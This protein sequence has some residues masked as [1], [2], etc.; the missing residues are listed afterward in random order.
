MVDFNFKDYIEI[1]GAVF[2]SLGGSTVI[3]LGLSKWF[4]DVFAQKL[5][6]GF[7]NRHEKDLEDL[8][9]GYQKELES[10]KV[11]L[12]KAKSQFLRYTEKQ[13]ELYNDLWKVLLY[14][15]N[16]ADSLWEVANPDQIPSFSEQIK[17]SK[18]AIDDNMLLIEESHYEKLMVLIKQ[19]EQFQ[20]G[21]IR[22]V[23]LRG[24][25]PEEIIEL[26]LTKEQIQQTI[27]LNKSIKD[28]YDNLI[29]EIG[30][31]FREQIKG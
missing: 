23:D 2:V 16:Q 27:G 9:S 6:L 26:G 25:T 29:M 30:K 15:K 5:I 11:E 7:K 20:F 12:D 18:D 19:F 31:T 17:L 14:T 13:F 10:T 24:Q 1:L 21:K 3:I 8:K 4:G 22:L 28:N